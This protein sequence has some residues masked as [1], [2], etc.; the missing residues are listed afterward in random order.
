MKLKAF[1]GILV[2][3]LIVPS[4][5]HAEIGRRPNTPLVAVKEIDP[6]WVTISVVSGVGQDNSWDQQQHPAQANALA[7][8]VCGLYNRKAVVLSLFGVPLRTTF[9]ANQSSNPIPY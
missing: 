1:L 4:I 8:F 5:V 3:V 9:T 6:N 2:T 7:A